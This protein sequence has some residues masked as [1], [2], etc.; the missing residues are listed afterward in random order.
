MAKTKEGRVKL[1]DKVADQ[2]GF[3]YKGNVQ[4][5]HIID[6]EEVKKD[7]IMEDADED[8]LVFMYT[9]KGIKVLYDTESGKIKFAV[10]YVE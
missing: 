1:V 10:R 5:L 8:D 3:Y 9:T 7:P 4:V 6:L 2:L